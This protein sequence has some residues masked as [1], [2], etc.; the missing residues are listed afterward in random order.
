MITIPKF[1]AITLTSRTI[2]SML[3]ASNGIAVSAL[4]RTAGAWLQDISHRH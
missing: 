1:M 4:V 3:R 2:M